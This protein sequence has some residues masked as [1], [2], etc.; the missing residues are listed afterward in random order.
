TEGEIGRGLL[1]FPGQANITGHIAGS[2]RMKAAALHIDFSV[3]IDGPVDFQGDKPAEASP[4]AKLGS[5]VHFERLKHGPDYSSGHYYVWR[6][7]WTAA[8]IL[9]GLV[10]FLLTPTFAAET[11]SAAER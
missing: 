5:P 2:A 6:V 10:L 4:R 8:F 7:I 3:Q 9:F 11:V 1:A